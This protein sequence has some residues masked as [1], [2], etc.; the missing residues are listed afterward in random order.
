MQKWLFQ[1][2]KNQRTTSKTTVNY[3]QDEYLKT[4]IQISKKGTVSKKS[5][6]A[7]I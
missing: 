7:V 5:T 4:V 2:F 6:A 3:T 1:A